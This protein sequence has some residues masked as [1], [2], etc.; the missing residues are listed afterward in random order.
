MCVDIAEAAVQA[1]RERGL[2]AYRGAIGDSPLPFEDSS[3]D[4]VHMAEVIE[5]L[6]HPDRAMEEVYRIL[7]PQGY[8]VL[9]TPN[10][11]CLPNRFLV[12]FGFQPIFTEV[13][14]DRVLGRGF[15]ILGQG[16]KPVGH[17]RIY[18][19]RSLIEFV[20]MS[21]FRPLVMRGVPL[22]SNGM[23]AKLEQLASMRQ[24][25]AMI[26]VL[27]AQKSASAASG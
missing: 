5:H 20:K 26:L 12:P 2:E 15:G 21:G 27:L 11:S 10:L 3:F 22:H 6:V 7:R 9:S 13:S 14:E 24:S 25:W 16:T 18:T 8:L 19:K 17:L 4:L 23:I 1:C